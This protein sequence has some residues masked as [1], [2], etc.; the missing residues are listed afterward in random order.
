MAEK[1]RTIRDAH[2]AGL[3]FKNSGRII[4]FARNFV[5]FQ[6]KFFLTSEFRLKAIWKGVIWWQNIRISIWR[7]IK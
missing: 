2:K 6:W 1:R 5:I 4:V 3:N 7:C